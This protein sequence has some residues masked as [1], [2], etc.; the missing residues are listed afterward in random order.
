MDVFIFA[1][2][3][4][5]GLKKRSLCKIVFQFHRFRLN[6]MVAKPDIVMKE[7]GSTAMFYQTC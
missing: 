3:T 5:S 1:L 2:S 4:W 7:I 6:F